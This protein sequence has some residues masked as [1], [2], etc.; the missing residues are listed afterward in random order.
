MIVS[1]GEVLFDVFPRYRRLGGAPFNFIHHLGAL[2]FETRF[3]SRVGN[4]PAGWEILEF[5]RSRGMAPDFVQRDPD[6]PTGQVKVTLDPGGNP[7]FRIIPDVAYDAIESTDA[8]RRLV[9]GADMIYF[10]SLIQRSGNGFDQVQDLLAARGEK[11]RCLYDVNLRP[12][13]YSHAIIRA[14]L[15]HC[16]LLKLN[17]DELPEVAA[18]VGF[19]G[20]P[21]D[22][23]RH[24]MDDRGIEVIALTLGKAGSRLY[25]PAG[26]FTAGPSADLKVVDAVGAGDAYAAVLAAGYLKGWDGDRLLGAATGFAGQVCRIE[27]AIPSSMEFYAPV[28]QALESR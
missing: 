1:I 7:S 17:S 3:V 18:A 5:L 6:R 22:F 2:G 10:G 28:R 11:T 14:S 26:V 23:I 16:H 4:D 24:L 20:D 27:G 9:A 8:A 19:T 15:R 13:A 12:D 25:T 21:E